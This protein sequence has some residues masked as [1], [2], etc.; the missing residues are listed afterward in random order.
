MIF[1]KVS[2]RVL[3]TFFVFVYG[4]AVYARDMTGTWVVHPKMTADFNRDNAV[5]S[6]TEMTLMQ[7]LLE[8]QVL[9]ATEGVIIS[10][11]QDCSMFKGSEMLESIRSSEIFTYRILLDEGD[12]VVMELTG[13]KDSPTFGKQLQVCHFVNENTFWVYYYGESTRDE[14]HLRKYYRRISQSG[15][16]PPPGSWKD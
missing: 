13:D 3:L 16:T 4:V 2:A 9:D 14:V 1:I 11:T 5:V 8:A 12:L 15:L 10:D 7:C 6:E